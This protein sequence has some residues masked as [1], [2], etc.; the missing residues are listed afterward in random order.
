MFTALTDPKLIVAIISV[1]TNVIGLFAKADPVALNTAIG[2][3]YLY[4]LALAHSE[5]GHVAPAPKPGTAS[6]T[7]TETISAASKAAP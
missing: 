2:P 4:V 6:V 3:L 5:S 1:I 7:A